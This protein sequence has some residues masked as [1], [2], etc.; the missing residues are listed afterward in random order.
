MLSRRLYATM[1][2]RLLTG[3]DRAAAL[4]PLA[5]RGW[6]D[7][8]PARDGIEK[9]YV[10]RDFVEAWG[11]MSRVALLAEKRDHHPDWRNVYNKVTVLWETHDLG[12]LSTWDTEL[13]ARCDEAAG[14]AAGAGAGRS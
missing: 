14:E 2:R 8:A 1:P 10:F 5:S 11:F 6:R 12:G 9:T 7:L 4:A 3:A 13:A